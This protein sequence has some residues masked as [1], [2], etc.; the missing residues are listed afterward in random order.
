MNGTGILNDNGFED[1]ASIFAI[2]DFEDGTPEGEEERTVD[3][4]YATNLLTSLD[5]TIGE[6]PSLIFPG[7]FLSNLSNNFNIEYGSA[8]IVVSPAT[9]WATT[10]DLEITYGTSLTPSDFSTVISGYVY[11]ETQAVVFPSEEQPELG[12][13]PYFLVDSEGNEYE[14]SDLLEV[15]EYRIK[16]KNPQNYII[17]DSDQIAKLKIVIRPLT[18]SSEPLSVTYGDPL[19]SESFATTF[20][21]FVGDVEDTDFTENVSYY[22]VDALDIDKRFEISDLL[23]VGDYLIRIEDT[24]RYTIGYSDTDLGLTVTKKAL[25]VTTTPLELEYGQPL[26]LAALE[27]SFKDLEG[28][29]EPS[30]LVFPDGIPYYFMTGGDRIELPNVKN[31]GTY[32]IRIDQTVTIPKNY[33]L[34]Y[35]VDHGDFII[36]PKTL[37]IEPQSITREYGAPLSAEQ[38]V[39]ENLDFEY[40]EDPVL[41]YYFIDD[42]NPDSVFRDDFP[43]NVGRYKI[44]INEDDDTVFANYTLTYG[45]GLYT[46]E[47]RELSIAINDLVIEEGAVILNSDISLQSNPEGFVYEDT[48]FSVFGSTI[49]YYF[50]SAQGCTLCTRGYRSIL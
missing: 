48:T 21:G 33:F 28:E 40:N 46:I 36:I 6:E 9:L 1:F 43:I 26:T 24:H 8:N 17:D 14:I 18:A 38:I 20:S 15:G 45:S 25:T 10:D 37:I 49:P 13:I 35:G 23:E 22:L 42:N 31:V 50:V 3:K 41:S 29:V 7:A 19:S 32:Q 44:R 30:S 27:T 47:K 4:I 39:L 2:V 12:E 16:I 5:V 11:G 34:E